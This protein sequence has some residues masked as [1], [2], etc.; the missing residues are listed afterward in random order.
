MT[1]SPKYLTKEE[2][3]R[4]RGDHFDEVI[5]LGVKGMNIHLVSSCEDPIETCSILEHAADENFR[6]LFPQALG[7]EYVH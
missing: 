6:K 1:N 7:N 5:M 4:I 3:E 2:L